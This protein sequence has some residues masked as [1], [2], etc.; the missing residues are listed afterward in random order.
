M[1]LGFNPDNAY[2]IKTD[3]TV[4]DEGDILKFNS[5]FESGNLRKVIQIRKNEYDLIL[6]AD[7]NSNHYHQWFYFEVSGM[8]AAIAYR[9]NIINCEKSNSQFNYGAPP[10]KRSPWR[11]RSLMVSPSP[12]DQRQ[13]DWLTLRHQLFQRWA[14]R[15][16]S[17]FI[18]HGQ[19]TCSVS[20][21][22]VK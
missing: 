5:K 17:P 16:P 2:E 18:G 10:T 7:I 15:P 21:F 12:P 6:N 3:Y 19:V 11:E 1:Q 13:S 4:P 20:A 14:S 22:N 8:R 9:F